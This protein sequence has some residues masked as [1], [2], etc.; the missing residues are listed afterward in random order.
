MIFERKIVFI[1]SAKYLFLCD[2]SFE[3]LENKAFIFDDKILEFNK[4]EILLKK[5]PNAKLIKTP[6]NS[7]I[8]PA[9]INPHTHLEF[10]ANTTSLSFGEFLTWLK[11]VISCRFSLNEQAKE[12]LILDKIKKILKTGTGTIGEISSF[13]SDLKPC[14]KAS[15]NGMRV[16]FFNEILG[17]NEELLEQK[18]AEFLA[19]FQ[20]SLKHKNELFIPA[21]SIHSAYSTHPELA[22]FALNL[23]KK[24]KSLVSTHLLE[25]KAEN[26]WLR[27]KTGGFKKWLLNFTKNPKPFY[28][29]EEFISLFKGFRTLFTHCVYL[30]EFE[31]LDKNLHSITHCAFSN[32][33]LSQKSLN[34]KKAFQSGLNTHLGTDGLSS[35]ISLSMLDEMRANLLVH[36]EFELLNLAKKLLKM[37]TLYPARALG[38]NLGELKVGKIADFSVFELEISSKE[39]AALH[40]IL[41]AKEVNKIFIKGKECKF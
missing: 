41:N 33:L 37:A 20:N 12:E 25:S 38:L 15:E 10:S 26:L 14:L 19:K 7:I 30:K 21:V 4:L 16:I 18:K 29:I 39:Q 23:A 22:K 27:K 34:L 6:E 2:E 24:N 11:S 5:Y 31:L 28:S 3:I 36:K 35:N 13:A 9:F 17:T 40:F 32:V 8:L 1:I